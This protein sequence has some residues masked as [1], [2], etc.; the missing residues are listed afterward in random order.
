MRGPVCSPYSP[1]PLVVP[2]K[3]PAPA[4]VPR[5][6]FLARQPPQLQGPWWNP[7]ARWRAHPVNRG[8]QP[9]RCPHIYTQQGTSSDRGATSTINYP[10]EGPWSASATSRMA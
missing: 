2:S 7:G 5:P 1:A 6:A 8:Q 3:A 9:V 4:M 10:P